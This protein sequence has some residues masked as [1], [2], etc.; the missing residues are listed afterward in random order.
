MA[1]HDR[2]SI[3]RM[4]AT[5]VAAKKAYEYAGLTSKDIQ[6]AEVHDAF[7]ISEIMAI[8]D[9][10]FFE[11]GKGGKATLDG[12]TALNSGISINTSGGL[13]CKGHPV[14]AT[15][16]Y[17]LVEAT[18]QL[19]ESA[20]KAQ[21]DGVSTALTQNIGGSGATIVAHILQKP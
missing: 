1:L 12:E 9:L 6:L 14:G 17:Q 10:G 16:L 18:L 8:E 20:G 21:I 7:S 15:G 13:K 5:A 3:T 11:K 4:D 2:P 19:R